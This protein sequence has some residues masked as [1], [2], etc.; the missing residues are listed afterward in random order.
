MEDSSCA[1]GI[2]AMRLQQLQSMLAAG[3]SNGFYSW[4]EWERV[5]DVVLAMDH[6]ECQECRRRHRYSR[7]VLVHHVQHLRDRPD[8]ALSVFDPATGTR[9]LLSLC[10]PCH[11]AQHPE[12]MRQHQIPKPPVTLERWD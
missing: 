7:A 9:Q 3:T 2:S 8:L 11:E 12:R 6:W 5:R 10:R 4:P 1:N